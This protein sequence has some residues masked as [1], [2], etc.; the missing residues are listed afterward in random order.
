MPDPRIDSW[1]FKSAIE[2]GSDLEGIKPFRRTIF[3]LFMAATCLTMRELSTNQ[4]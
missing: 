4:A 2:P 3:T 1:P